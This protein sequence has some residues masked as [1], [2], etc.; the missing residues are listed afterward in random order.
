METTVQDVKDSLNDYYK[1]TSRSQEDTFAGLQ[2]LEE[3]IAIL[4]DALGQ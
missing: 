4:K 1:D 3:E 2:E